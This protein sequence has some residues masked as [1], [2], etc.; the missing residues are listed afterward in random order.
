MTAAK[1]TL[2][3]TVEYK[4]ELPDGL[5]ARFLADLAKRHGTTLGSENYSIWEWNPDEKVVSAEVV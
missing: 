4:I 2:I 3:I 5:V 1:T